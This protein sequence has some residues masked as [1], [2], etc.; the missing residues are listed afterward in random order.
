MT[1]E[2]IE[3]EVENLKQQLTLLQK[4]LATTRRGWIPWCRFTGMVLAL[5]G[6]PFIVGALPHLGSSSPMV[7]LLVTMLLLMG[8]FMALSGLCL[9]VFSMPFLANRMFWRPDPGPLDLWKAMR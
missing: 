2:K 5:W 9:W 1:Q 6:L 4:E 7:L 3:T 8:L